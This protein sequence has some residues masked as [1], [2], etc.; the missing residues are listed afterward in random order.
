MRLKKCK[1][2]T[3]SGEPSLEKIDLWWDYQIT[4]SCLWHCNFSWLVYSLLILFSFHQKGEK[5][6]IY[7]SEVQGGDN[8]SN[9][10]SFLCGDTVPRVFFE[11]KALFILV[12]LN[13][14]VLGALASSVLVL[15]LQRLTELSEVL[16]WYLII[17]KSWLNPWRDGYI[18]GISWLAP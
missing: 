12:V 9:S 13:L 11:N 14:E 16:F 8:G 1:T 5:R 15:W 18:Q 17:G 6:N 4:W 7:Y 3:G 10:K 2:F